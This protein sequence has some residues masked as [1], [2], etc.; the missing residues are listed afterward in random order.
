MSEVWRNAD[1]GAEKLEP[2]AVYLSQL[3]FALLK[4]APDPDAVESSK[5]LKSTSEEA[6]SGDFHVLLTGLDGPFS[7]PEE[8][9]PNAFLLLSLPG[10]SFPF[11]SHP[12][13][14]AHCKC[15]LF[16]EGFSD[17]SNQM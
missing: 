9:N 13:L 16:N 2:S 12:S 1:G 3:R 7:G 10:T 11:R 5:C 6:V 14:K 4:P 17:F 8:P 15:I